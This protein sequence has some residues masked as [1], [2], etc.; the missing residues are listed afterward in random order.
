MSSSLSATDAPPRAS[1]AAA[2]ERSLALLAHERPTNAAR[3]VRAMTG[4]RA[5]VHV[6]DEDFVVIGDGRA[7]RVLRD[8]AAPR[9]DVDV[10]LRVRR[11]AL[12]EV[13]DARRSLAQAL[14]DGGLEV[15]GPLE[16]IFRLRAALLAY[17]H[18]AVRCRSFP[19]LLERYRQ[20][21]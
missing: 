14:R 7:V 9:V 12:L 21:Q 16:T 3:F 4:L 2:L 6:D 1:T 10:E 8:E 17:V 20:M 18:G 5:R 19:A 11:S 15:H 13:L